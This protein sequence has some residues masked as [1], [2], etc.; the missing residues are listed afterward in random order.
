MSIQSA[1]TTA[2]SSLDLE[3]QLA[4]VIANNIA[5]ASTPG[6][7]TETLPQI[8]QA[9]G[10]QSSGVM[11]G[12]LQR[13]GDEALEAT[14][15]QAAGQQSYSQALVNSLTSY[16]AVLGQP[17]DSSSLP[18]QFSAFNQALTSLAAN[19]DD[20][21]LQSGAVT[22]AQ[23]LVSTFNSLSAAIAG[24]REQADQTIG[25]DVTTVNQTLDQLAQNEAALQTASAS[26]QSTASYLD[27]RDQLLSTLSQ[28][29]PVKVDQDGNNGIVVTTDG[30]TTLYDGSAHPL[31]FTPTPNIPSQLQETA[32]PANGY[33]GG[34]S[35]VTVD[36][37]PIAI[38]QS[39]DIAAQLQ[40][41]DVT[42][43]TFG[44]QL[45]QLAGNTIV[46]FQQA[47]PTVSNGETGIF[48]NAGAAVDP[49]NPAEIP[50]LAANIALNASV[51]PTQ[52][53]QV[54]N[55]V[56]GAQATGQGPETGDNSTV[57]A[58]I[59]AMNT[60]Q[61]YT[62]STGLQNSMTLT[63]AVSQVAG[64]QQETLSTW[65]A[66]NTSRGTLAQT[67][68]TALSNATGVNVDDELQRLIT[69]QAT[70]AATT[71]VIQAATKM[72][73]DLNQISIT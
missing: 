47:D 24:G 33:V 59:Q 6:Y 12:V 65:T 53:G 13:L 55:I 54:S 11:A 49:N 16:T 56:D 26:G 28:Y 18:E 61:N 14:A 62:A 27:T 60:D 67:A 69:V 7:V 21:S 35:A 71:Q 70:Y 3:Q 68:Q 10:G 19:P 39:G 1:L 51:D 30:G 20:A 46:A 36:G 58:F 8:E 22:A 45:D 73:D 25:S 34:L 15:N 48:T 31:S 52:G 64:Q 29:L 44:Q 5:N 9:S 63:N 66:N 42:L 43:P 40:L 23:S 2:S 57:L 17:T 4:N 41:R 37:Q 50:G 72:Y 32:D 38:S